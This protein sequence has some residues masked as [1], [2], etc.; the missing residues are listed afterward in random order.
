M[1]W[2]EASNGFARLG[3]NPELFARGSK[4][5]FDSC[6]VEVRVEIESIFEEIIVLAT[7]YS[8]LANVK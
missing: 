7:R 2:R 3:Y 1:V 6:C 8:N 4:G 5:F